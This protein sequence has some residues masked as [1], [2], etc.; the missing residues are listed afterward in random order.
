MKNARRPERGRNVERKARCAHQP[1]SKYWGFPDYRGLEVP[2]PQYRSK[3]GHGSA[4]PQ[5]TA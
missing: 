1:F 2:V 4:V 5:V 3:V